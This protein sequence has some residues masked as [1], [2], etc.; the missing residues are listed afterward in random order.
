MALICSP[1]TSLILVLSAI[2]STVFGCS[3]FKSSID[4]VER[5]KQLDEGRLTPPPER[6]SIELNGYCPVS[7]R[8][9]E[10]FY[11]VNFST[12]VDGGSMLPDSDR[13]GIADEIE[14][15]LAAIYNL[16]P[17][18]SD[19][20]GDG[21]SDL[22][23]FLSGIRASDQ[24]R[25]RCSDLL[26]NDGDG[27]IYMAPSGPQFLGLRNCEENGLALTGMDRFDSDGDDIPDYLE[28][29]CGL[30]PK[31]MWDAQID[32]DGDGIQNIEEC[33]IATPYNDSNS[34]PAISRHAYKYMLKNETGTGNQTCVRIDVDNVGVLGAGEGDLMVLYLIEMEGAQRKHL[35]SG[36]FVVPKVAQPGET[37]RTFTVEFTQMTWRGFQ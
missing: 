28:L 3:F 12:H 34:D 15:R 29:R 16:S 13:D 2:M 4:E 1:H 7:G 36:Y 37:H 6:I 31:N 14:N 24:S 27:L 5:L 17:L 26:D 30:N 8:Q 11:A 10:Q 32:S 9:Y 20:N 35:Y 25:L 21:I 22:L 19:T 18:H 23:I 33:K